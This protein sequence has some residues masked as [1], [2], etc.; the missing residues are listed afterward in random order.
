MRYK[1]QG[2]FPLPKNTQAAMET[3]QAA[4]EQTRGDG[5]WNFSSLQD[6]EQYAM[7]VT[8]MARSTFYKYLRQARAGGQLQVRNR[9]EIDLNA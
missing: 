1:Q 2:L 3:I 4:L 8:G 7:T 9:I 6:F 5:P